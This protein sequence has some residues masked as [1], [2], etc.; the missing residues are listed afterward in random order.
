M[1][2]EPEATTRR[3]RVADIA[4]TPWRNGGGVTRQIATGGLTG[5]S[6]EEDTTWGW[7]VSLAEVVA[8]GPFSIFPE[9][10]RLIAVIEGA[11]MDLQAAD[12]TSLALP[13]FQP[14]RFAGEVPYFGRLSDG[15]VRDLNVMV[16]RGHYDGNMEIRQGP[17]RVE[18]ASEPGGALLL[19]N[20]TG[21]CRLHLAKS[22]TDDL[23]EAE[24]LIHEGSGSV[25]L[26]LEPCAP[27]PCGGS[28][29]PAP[30]EKLKAVR[31]TPLIS[32]QAEQ[33]AC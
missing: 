1:T 31:K 13:P 26:R 21:A 12:G 27:R 24:V 19:L 11:G 2:T 32:V 3:L 6:A 33:T 23:A 7:R 28:A 17:C 20:L 25:R 16:R 5:V 8:E 10:D 9:T 29:H 22:G 4:A 14:V 15:P 30:A 18:A